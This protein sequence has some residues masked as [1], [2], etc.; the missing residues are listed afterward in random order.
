MDSTKEEPAESIESL[1]CRIKP[2]LKQLASLKHSLS[3]CLKTIKDSR[4]YLMLGISPSCSDEEVKR[5][6][7]MMAVKL[8]PDKPGGST[9]YNNYILY[10]IL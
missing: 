6:Y 1:N 4:A 2:Y 9:G 3:Q 8:H 5:A 10:D 7:R